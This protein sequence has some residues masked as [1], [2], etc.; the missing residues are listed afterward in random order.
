MK[1]QDYL[2]RDWILLAVAWIVRLLFLALYP[3]YDLLQDR[4]YM[5]DAQDFHLKALLYLG[6][7]V[8]DSP[9][10]AQVAPVYPAFIAGIYLF[11]GESYVAIRCA[12][13]LL[14]ALT[15]VLVR[16]IGA[17]LWGKQTGF[18]AGYAL[19]FYYPH[20]Q[21]SGYVATETLYT[22]LLCLA[23]LPLSGLPKGDFLLR[24]IVG[25]SVWTVSIA[26]RPVSIA[27]L[28]ALGTSLLYALWRKNLSPKILTIATICLSG[29]SLLW[30][31]SVFATSGRTVPMVIQMG[32]LLYEGNSEHA[33]GGHG[34]HFTWDDFVL[35]SDIGPIGSIDAD[36]RLFALAIEYMKQHPG[37]CMLLAMK[38]TW[39][40][41]RPY[42]FDV[43][44]AAKWI[45]TCSY[46][47]L[48]LGALHVLARRRLPLFSR[49]FC[50]LPLL[51]A[52]TLHAVLIGQIRY[53]YPLDPF[54]LLL[55]APAGWTFLQSLP[56][57][58]GKT[59]PLQDEGGVDRQGSP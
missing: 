56:R 4:T 52:A 30:L 8:E 58:Q 25:T 20:L 44:P 59:P 53:R 19:A 57:F 15:C 1:I 6:K 46:L 11:L 36:R 43:T 17:H 48:W 13:C 12:Q 49:I 27:F 14:G 55:A 23:A 40:M 26:V 9:A 45:H 16:R 47:A 38:K 5:A 34:G 31:A 24:W 35:P 18:L 33:T 41:W 22:F 51:L 28:P 37:H 7:E 54:L 39:N 10:L 21:L 50:V 42:H 32:Q 2:T 29:S 3:R